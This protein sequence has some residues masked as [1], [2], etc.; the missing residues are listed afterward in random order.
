MLPLVL[1]FTACS[2]QK[3]CDMIALV[4]L[5]ML[6]RPIDGWQR[7]IRADLKRFHLASEVTMLRRYKQTTAAA[8]VALAAGDVAL[9]KKLTPASGKDVFRPGKT[10]G[11]DPRAALRYYALALEA[12]ASLTDVTPAWLEL[13][14]TRIPD[15]DRSRPGGCWGWDS[16]WCLAFAHFHR[17]GGAPAEAVPALLRKTLRGEL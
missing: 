12:K 5:A 11:D 13:L 14:V 6:G 17:I 7:K 8:A 1:G 16:L 3:S 4:F 9:V 2:T 10:Y 15:R